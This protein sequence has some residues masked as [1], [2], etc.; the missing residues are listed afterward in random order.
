[1]TSVSPDWYFL[2]V[3]PEMCTYRFRHLKRPGSSI[4]EAKVPRS[5]AMMPISLHH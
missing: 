5:H 1:M 2:G 3:K 4:A